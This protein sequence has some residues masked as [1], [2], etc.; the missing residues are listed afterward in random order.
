MVEFNSLVDQETP[1]EYILSI[2]DASNVKG[3]GTGI[4]LE[5]PDDILIEQALKFE[6]TAINKQAEYEALIDGKVMAL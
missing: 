4:V 6:F 5:G 2:D 1:Q 3:S